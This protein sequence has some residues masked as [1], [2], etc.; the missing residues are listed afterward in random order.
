MQKYPGAVSQGRIYSLL[1]WQPLGIEL[2]N[3][4]HIF[5][6]RCTQNAPWSC[7]IALKCLLGALLSAVT[8]GPVFCSNLALSYLRL[9]DTVVYLPTLVH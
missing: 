1:G 7:Y 2:R 6:L 5:G 8:S 3:L 4:W 9:E